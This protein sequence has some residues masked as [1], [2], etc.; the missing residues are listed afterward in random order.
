MNLS[1]DRGEVAWVGRRFRVL[2]LSLI[3]VAILV[4]G[5]GGLAQ[6]A[7]ASGT[8]GAQVGF[9]YENKQLQPAKYAFLIDE[10]GAGHFHSQPGDPPPADTR[11]YQS[12]AEAQDRPVQLSKPV[13]QQVFSTARGQKY[14]AIKCEDSKDKIAFQGMKQLSYQGPDGS[15]TCTYN[16]SK[17]TAIE[18]LTT[19][20]ESIAFTLEEG[21]RLEVE[22]KHD[23]LA[24]DAE[25][26]DLLDAVKDGRALELHSIQP[27]LQEIAD[28]DAV[29][30]RARMRAKKLLDAGNTT[31]SLR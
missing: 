30:E 5:A 24:L 8:A 18:K 21:R 11:S 13:V 9:T 28:D 17:S 22:H 14:F 19:I 20:F 4:C 12:L 2:S 16:W 27:V 7:N 29:L 6:T 31:A 23:R 25:L 10:S 1:D 15:G 26:G 3:A